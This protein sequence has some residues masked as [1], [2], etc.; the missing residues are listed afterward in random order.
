MPRPCSGFG[1]AIPPSGYGTTGGAGGGLQDPAGLDV[2]QNVA[3]GLT[4]ILPD[5]EPSWRREPS[6]TA[7]ALSAEPMAASPA[8]ATGHGPGKQGKERQKGVVFSR[9]KMDERPGIKRCGRP[10]L[11][12]T[13]AVLGKFK[14]AIMSSRILRISFAFV[15]CALISPRSPADAP[16]LRAAAVVRLEGKF[17]LDGRLDDEVWSRAPVHTGFGRPLHAPDARPIPETEQTFFQVA[18]SDEALVFAVRMNEPEMNLLKPY[19]VP[20]LFDA[21]M[22]LHDD[23]EIFLDPVGDRAEYYQ[24]AIDPNGTR[25]D[26]YYIEHGNTFKPYSAEW[27]VATA[28]EAGAWTAEIVIPFAALW[29]RPST[30]WAETWGFSIARTRPPPHSNWGHSLY[31]PVNSA[32]Y[33]DS[34][35]FGTLGPLPPAPAGFTLFADLPVFRLVPEKEGFGFEAEFDL[36]NRGDVAAE[37]T[38]SLEI[39]GSGSPVLSAPYRLASGE[40]SRIR[41]PGGRVPA[42]GD[43]PVLVRAADTGGRQRLAARFAARLEYEP[44]ILRLTR[45]NYRD[46][47]Y[48][49][50]APDTIRGFVRLGELPEPERGAFVRV[51][52]GSRSLPPRHVDVA[53]TALEIPF[54]LSAAGIPDGEHRLSAQLLRPVP[55]A[56]IDA[57]RPNDILLEASIPLRRLGPGTDPEVRVDEAGRLL[58]DGIPLFARGWYGNFEYRVSRAIQPDAYTPRTVN[59]MQGFVPGST[60]CFVDLSR[61]IDE[62]LAQTDLPLDEE[63]KIRLRA[64]I[65][66]TRS[67]RNVI[68]YYLS[69]EPECRGLSK[70]YLRR[71]YEFVRAEDPYRACLIISRSPAE[72]IEA[73]DIMCPHPYMSPSEKEDGT[74]WLGIPLP[75][76]RTTLR[77]AASVRGASKVIWSMPQAFTYGGRFG[78]NPTFDESRWFALTSLANGAQGLV[79]FIYC[80]Y[81]AHLANKV[82][83][84]SIFEDTL[85]LEKAWLSPGSEMPITCDTPGVDV[86][87]RTAPAQGQP[88][89]FLV[90]ANQEK[91]KITARFRSEALARAGV[92]RLMVLRE[93]RVV[94]VR[95]GEFT[96]TFEPLGSRIYTTL[97]MLPPL[98]SLDELRAEVEAGQLKHRAEGNLMADPSRIWRVLPRPGGDPLEGDGM[99]RADGT[100]TDGRLDTAGWMSQVRSPGPFAVEFEK[101]VVFSRLRLVSPTFKDATLEVQEGGGW[102]KLHEWRDQVSYNMEWSGGPV[103]TRV[104]RVTGTAQRRHFSPW[105]Y[106]EVTEMGLYAK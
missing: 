79:P 19:E 67:H 86:V 52:L 98:C 85:L 53:A 13:V 66:G 106:D 84:D 103:T 42:I 8:G 20:G 96:D 12:Q 15:F 87:G 46:T 18:V 61:Q 60:Y 33:H 78:R 89:V 69:D 22:W 49:S 7:P 73:C 62:N 5:A 93:N 4:G 57:R 71:V 95:N 26:Q 55:D 28:R 9:I 58:V 59:L 29:Q 54:E 3:G 47:I 68:G 25:S 17:V 92:T 70:H 27:R 31:S 75:H 83:W 80:G 74:R 64:L 76:L 21:A 104:V 43:S 100:L 97:E 50:A 56:K 2:P 45:P 88:I 65:A 6:A 37:G 82:A 99:L 30:Q 40:T 90:A 1:S 36:S 77:T 24:F 94:E 11:V 63:T 101:P 14:E 105:S 32:G 91:G 81:T 72:Y 10:A 48:S 16:P 39:P 51:T 34:E 23:V 44:I 35:T 41:L 38:V 102:R